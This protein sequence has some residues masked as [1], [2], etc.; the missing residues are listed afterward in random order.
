MKK[1]IISAVMAIFAV[2]F[3]A[4]AQHGIKIG[5]KAGLAASWIPGTTLLGNERVMPHTSF[6]A[7]VSGEYVFANNVVA[8]MEVLYAGKGH[9][10]RSYSLADA[11]VVTEKYN[12]EIGYVQIPLFGGYKF[13]DGD[14]SVMVGPEFGIAVLGQTKK[15]IMDLTGSGKDVTVKKDVREVIRPFNIALALQVSY[16]FAMGLGVDAKISYGLNKTF[17][18]NMLNAY[19]I[20]RND[21]GHNMTFQIGLF[22][23]FEL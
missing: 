3:A 9:T 20:D 7:G 22:Y 4:N 15:T 12:L 2:S 14:M 17:K 13:F 18:D 11:S 23:K 1:A 5:P 8:Q 19:G 10:D 6:Y 21:K 16:E